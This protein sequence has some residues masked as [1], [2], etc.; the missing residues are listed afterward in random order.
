MSSQINLHIHSPAAEVFDGIAIY[1]QLKG[2][3][4]K[5]TVYID[6]LAAS[7][8]SVIAMVGDTVIMPENA[9]MMIHKP[10]RI[11][12][13]DADE[14]RDYADLLDKLENVLIPYV[15]KTSKTAEEIAAMLEEE[16]WMNGDECLSHGFA[17]QLLTRYRRWPVSHQ[18]YRGLYCYATEKLY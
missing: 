4:A 18:T 15:A 11:A 5:I 7:M 12:W 13:D 8:A 14:M 17:D 9:M 1:N 10:L 6:R 16:T 2:H 3:D